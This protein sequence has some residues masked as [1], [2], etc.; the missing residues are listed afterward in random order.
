MLKARVVMYQKDTQR[1]GEVTKDMAEI[2][3]S[4]QFDLA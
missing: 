2:I 3:G 1:Y 4:A